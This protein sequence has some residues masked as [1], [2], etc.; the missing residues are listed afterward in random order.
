M[1]F[2]PFILMLQLTPVLSTE[3]SAASRQIA[4]PA[5]SFQPTS[6]EIL[7]SQT[8]VKKR[9]KPGRQRY[10]FK[11]LFSKFISPISLKLNHLFS[12]KGKWSD[13][14]VALISGI[15]TLVLFT[16]YFIFSNSYLF[17]F[18]VIAMI[19]AIA[20][21]SLARKESEKTDRIYGKIGK[22]LWI[23]GLIILGFL[24]LTAYLILLTVILAA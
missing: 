18:A 7:R 8:K 13:G 11:Q 19:Y 12:N 17:L 10:N 2:L 4:F 15:A 5:E 20:F 23:V 9:R 24:L 16:L 1:I 3:V 6:N 22:G 21:G 14:K